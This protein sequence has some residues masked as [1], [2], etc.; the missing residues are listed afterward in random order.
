MPTRAIKGVDRC[1][2]C[3]RPPMAGRTKCEACLV[4]H[5]WRMRKQRRAKKL[6]GLCRFDGCR[7]PT[8]KDRAYCRTHLLY[9][10]DWQRR[11]SRGEAA[12]ERSGS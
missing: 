1:N 8:A 10:A 11:K 2:D 5:R 12:L 3:S 7:S 9:Y 6:E 4:A